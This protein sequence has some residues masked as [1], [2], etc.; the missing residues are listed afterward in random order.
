MNTPSAS[1]PS[2]LEL[3][4]NHVALP[5]RLPGKHDHKIEDIE[6]AMTV[7]LL[8]A[9]RELRDLMYKEFGDQWDT[10][11]RSLQ[12]CKTVNAGGKLNKASLV[13]E[14]RRLEPK[15]L[16]ILHVTEQNAGL[17]VRRHHE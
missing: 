13:V 6:Y 9:S 16:L 12:I 8:N 11:C 7:R 2:T 5:P 14:F 4:F 3:L 1:L 17:I 15:D 10:I